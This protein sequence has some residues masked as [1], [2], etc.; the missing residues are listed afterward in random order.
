MKLDIYG[1]TEKA[2]AAAYKESS[3]LE[4]NPVVEALQLVEE[5]MARYNKALDVAL[6]PQK[7]YLTDIEFEIYKRG[8]KIRPLMLILCARMV[9]GSKEPLPQKV[10]NAAVSTEML[11]VATLIHDDIIDHAPMRRGIPSVNKQRGIDMAILIGD[12]QFVQAIRCFT[13]SIETE[14]DM[15]LVRLVL[16]TAFK[17]CCGEIDELQ[18]DPDWDFLTLKGSYFQTIERKTAILFGVACECG[19]ALGGGHTREARR[20]GFYGR[21]IGRAFQIIDDVF[22]IAKSLDDTGKFPGTDLARRRLSL[23]IIYAMNELGND[24]LVTKIMKG[25][26]FTQDE[27][28]Q[29]LTAIR[30]SDGFVQSLLD[31]RAEIIDSMRYLDP[32]PD[33][34]Y[35]KALHDIAYY[36]INRRY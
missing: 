24:H 18:T 30:H 19:V 4:S 34:E 36:I 33:N 7:P 6:A 35:K 5:D 2:T 16:N 14:Q 32:F 21:R 9:W 23:P 25:A 17:I 8:K 29:G 1:S 11:H 3:L 12:L 13:D 26:P 15:G 31:A 20:I 27:L 22:D 28:M 10:I